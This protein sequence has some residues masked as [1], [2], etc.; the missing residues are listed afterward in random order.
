MQCTH[1]NVLY[2]IYGRF[3]I[4]SDKDTQNEFVRM[5]IIFFIKYNIK[6]IIRSFVVYFHLEFTIYQF[7]F[8][9][10]NLP[11]SSL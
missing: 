10:Q 5:R 1:Q 11:V 9:L 6:N 4:T 8:N 2:F 7:E 3:S